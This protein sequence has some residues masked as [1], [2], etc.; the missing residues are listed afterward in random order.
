VKFL[1]RSGKIIIYD[2]DDYYLDIPSYSFSRHLNFGNRKKV[3]ANNL[4]SVDITLASTHFLKKLLQ[5]YNDNIIV[6][7]NTLNQYF[8]KKYQ[9]ATDT[10]KILITSNDNL[11]LLILKMALSDV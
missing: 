2:I 9:P 7:E 8:F 10:V 1:K 4:K 5:S 3:F 6:V 11:K